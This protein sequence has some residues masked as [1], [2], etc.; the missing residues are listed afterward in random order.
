MPQDRRDRSRVLFT[1]VR[2]EFNKRPRGMSC[3]SEKT[4]VTKQARVVKS[5][6]TLKIRDAR[7]IIN[8]LQSRLIIQ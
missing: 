3:T 8:V 6:D 2:N 5:P 1:S 4:H 7:D